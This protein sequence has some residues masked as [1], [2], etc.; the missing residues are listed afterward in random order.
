MPRPMVLWTSM[1]QDGAQSSG[2]ESKSRGDHPSDRY[3][4]PL[5]NIYIYIC[6]MMYV[7]T[8][9]IY[10]DACIYIYTYIYIHIVLHLFN[11]ICKMPLPENV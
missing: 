1:V 8:Y 9:Y 7:Y 10:N 11:M 6:I 4:L 2:D 5:Q 3:L